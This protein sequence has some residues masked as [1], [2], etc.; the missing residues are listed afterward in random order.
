MVVDE[1]AIWT[2]M[3]RTH[4]RAPIGERLVEAVPH[5]HWHTTT[6]IGAMD[7]TGIRASM[8]LEGA[9]DRDAFEAFLEQVLTP[10]LVPGEIVVMDNLSAHK[11][12]R[13]RE[14]I[15][16][17]GCRPVYLPPY[18][19]DLS[20]IEPGFGKFKTLLR[21]LRPRSVAELWDKAGEVLNQISASDAIG[22]FTHCGYLLQMK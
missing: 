21:K 5:A 17:A 22:Y 9:T 14:L 3:T 8:L 4:G 7:V 11:G 2:D 13:V 20:P 1:T 15:R 12:G 19:F 16:G 6:V 10:T 18:S